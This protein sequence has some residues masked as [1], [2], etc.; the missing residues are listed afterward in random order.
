MDRTELK[1]YHPLASLGAHTISH[2]ALARLMEAETMDEMRASADF[3]AAITGGRRHS[4]SPV[5]RA[6]A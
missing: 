5:A 6:L 1:A 4:P 3:V 2:R